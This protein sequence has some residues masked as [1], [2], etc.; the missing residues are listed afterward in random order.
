VRRGSKIKP[1]D[2]NEIIKTEKPNVI[3][4]KSKLEH[5]SSKPAIADSLSNDTNETPS[6]PVSTSQKKQVSTKKIIIDQ[7]L[8]ESPISSPDSC[9][10]EIQNS[11]R[12][13]TDLEKWSKFLGF[14]DP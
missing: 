2:Q 12:K 6:Q 9:I 10:K 14:F 11:I 5:F 13:K 8:A 4:E 7:L 3:K 1:Q